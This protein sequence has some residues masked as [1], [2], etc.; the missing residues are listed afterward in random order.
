MLCKTATHFSGPFAKDLGKVLKS[1]DCSSGKDICV[2]GENFFLFFHQCTLI[3][4]A[5][6]EETSEVCGG[7]TVSG[8]AGLHQEGCGTDRYH[9][10]QD[11]RG[12]EWRWILTYPPHY[13]INSVHENVAQAL[14][15]IKLQLDPKVTATFTLALCRVEI[16]QFFKA[17]RVMYIRSERAGSTMRGCYFIG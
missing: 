2:E 9:H 16:N 3:C 6:N 17:Q 15:S 1:K 5:R 12:Q 4:V 14:T 8:Q 11:A 10:S 7:L 13:H